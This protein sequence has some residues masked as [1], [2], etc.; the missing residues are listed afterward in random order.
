MTAGPER[1]EDI[2]DEDL[3]AEVAIGD[4][5][6]FEV[7]MRRHLARSIALAERVVGDPQEAE[8]IVQDAF[9][10]LWNHADQWRPGEGRFTTWL[11]RI[12]LNRAIDVR[13]RRRPMAPADLLD[14][15][16][17]PD[18]DAESLLAARQIAE[19]AEAAV[20]A[21][22]ERQRA[23][24]ALCFQDG[25]TCQEAAAAMNVTVSAMESL[26]V[27]ARRAVKA[28]LWPLIRPH[29]GGKA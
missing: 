5:Q 9:F 28:S 11:Y 8:D 14:D 23:A 15:R 3:I 21:L 18:P 2:Q 20:T 27:R 24:L 4:R 1:P 7:L 6:A 10:Q 16:P 13:R 12:V 25:L 26:L 17:A 19:R 29:E 22:P